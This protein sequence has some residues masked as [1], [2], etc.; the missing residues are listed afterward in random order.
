MRLHL[1]C[2]VS[3]DT[4][5]K[6]SLHDEKDDKKQRMYVCWLC[7]VI[8]IRKG[9]HFTSEHLSDFYS[10]LW[11]FVQ[12]S[13]CPHTS[14]IH[15]T[16][17]YHELHLGAFKLVLMPSNYVVYSDIAERTLTPLSYGN[18][19]TR[20]NVRNEGTHWPYRSRATCLCTAYS[21]IRLW[22]WSRKRVW[23]RDG[24]E[25][26]FNP[27]VELGW[28]RL[29]RVGCNLVPKTDARNNESVSVSIIRSTP[30]Y[31]VGR[32]LSQCRKFLPHCLQMTPCERLR[33]KR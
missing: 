6:L 29:G 28:D 21:I 18:S 22:S 20:M 5:L 9:A 25:D 30:M 4:L 32:L 31:L 1:L 2:L 14:K 7:L 26:L 13:I 33:N 23:A 11:A 19:P 27:R 10:V 8:F 16:R 3:M 24:R 17:S 12:V 15:R